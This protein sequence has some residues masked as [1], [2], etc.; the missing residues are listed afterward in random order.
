MTKFQPASIAAHQTRQVREARQA[1]NEAALVRGPQLENVVDRIRPLVQAAID[2]AAN[3]GWSQCSVP[4]TSTWTT[5]LEALAIPM[6]I[7]E[8]KEAGYHIQEDDGS[9]GF[10]HIIMWV[11]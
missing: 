1:A 11:S 7:K 2:A 10:T 4:L 3:E 5:R 6:V 9:G 8:L